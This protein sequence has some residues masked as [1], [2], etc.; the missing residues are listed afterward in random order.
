MKK[1]SEDRMSPRFH[2]K[3]EH[4]RKPTKRHLQDKLKALRVDVKRWEGWRGKGKPDCN[5]LDK[6]VD[7][8]LRKLNRDIAAIE[9]Q[10]K[11]DK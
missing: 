4:K 9:I 10:L 3:T 6:L 2:G 11:E 1:S 8:V 5:H 7:S